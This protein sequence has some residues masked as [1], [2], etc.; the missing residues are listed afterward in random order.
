MTF[1]GRGVRN[2]GRRTHA[3]R[4]PRLPRRASV[5]FR[6]SAPGH[7][8]VYPFSASSQAAF[9]LPGIRRLVRAEFDD[10]SRDRRPPSCSQACARAYRLGGKVDPVPNLADRITEP[11]DLARSPFF[12][13]QGTLVP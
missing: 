9:P 1:G 3:R 6:L 4:S 11:G 7:F 5:L 8:P 10:R 2:H 13:Y 12:K